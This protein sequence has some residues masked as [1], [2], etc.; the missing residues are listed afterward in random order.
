LNNATNRT[1]TT[2]AATPSA[3]KA[4]YDLAN[5]KA[6]GS[7]THPWGQI[8]SIPDGTLTQKGIVK[9]NNA[10]NRTSTTEAATPSAVK[11]AYD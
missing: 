9:L 6:A 7:H 3:V 8:T 5:S 4:A 10:T 1:S 11:A 2:E